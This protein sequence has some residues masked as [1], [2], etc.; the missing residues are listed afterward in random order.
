M[1][2]GLLANYCEECGD[3]L[4]LREKFLEEIGKL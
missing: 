2:A 3:K 4:S 1:S